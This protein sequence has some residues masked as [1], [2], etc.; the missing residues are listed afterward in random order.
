MKKQ[1]NSLAIKDKNQKNPLVRSG[2]GANFKNPAVL[3]LATLGSQVSRKCMASKLNRFAQYFGYQSLVECD[4]SQMKPEHILEFLTM[5]HWESERTFNCYLSCLKSV[6]KSAWQV[7]LM[8][9]ETLD[10]IQ[11]IKQHRVYRE[12]P[13]RAI[14]FEESHKL[15][16]AFEGFNKTKVIRDRAILALLLG[17]GLRRAE[18]ANLKQNQLKLKE[19]RIQLIGKGN[20]ERSVYLTA[21]VKSFLDDWLL[22]RSHVHSSVDSKHVFCRVLKNEKVIP[23]RPMD[24]ASIGRVVEHVYKMAGLDEKIT[25]HDLRRTFA[26]RLIEKNVDI[27]EVQKLMGHSNVTTTGHYVRKKDEAIRKAVE[28]IEL[29]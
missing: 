15:F 26:T 7:E 1:K 28:K 23:D 9:R 2:V 5:Q 19:D 22:I 18:V 17:C 11:A 12:Q 14:D 4:W 29:F 25:T 27:V 20:K 16:T 8:P 21:A 13:G 6:A 10:R 3:Y 24:V